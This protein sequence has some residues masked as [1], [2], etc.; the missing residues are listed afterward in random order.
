MK[1]DLI[2]TKNVQ[3]REN[4]QNIRENQLRVFSNGSWRIYYKIF[5]VEQF[6]YDILI[7]GE[8]DATRLAS[9]EEVLRWL[10]QI[11]L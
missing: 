2:S 8:D 9:L 10:A 7:T 11:G 1:Y 6:T 4:I 5:Q 3:L